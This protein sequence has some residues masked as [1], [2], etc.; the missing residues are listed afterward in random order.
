MSETKISTNETQAADITKAIQ[1]QLAEKLFGTNIL[2]A[3]SNMHEC[4]KPK[5]SCG[6]YT[7]KTNTHSC[8]GDFDC[9]NSFTDDQCNRHFKCGQTFNCHGKYEE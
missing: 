8:S 5:F 7:C 3:G 2:N 1:A 6:E 9:K 4:N